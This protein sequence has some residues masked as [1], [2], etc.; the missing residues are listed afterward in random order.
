M[1]MWTIPKNNDCPESVSEPAI[2][3]FIESTASAIV[4]RRMTTPALMTLEM[5]KPL[6]FLGYSAMAA[7]SPILEAI[8]DQRKTNAMTALLGDRDRIERLMETIEKLE[9]QKSK[10]GESREP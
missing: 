2:S 10:E 8:F 5:V 1:G 7:F 6:S 4:R 3:E 9:K